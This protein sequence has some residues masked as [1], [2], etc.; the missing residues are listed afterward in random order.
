MPIQPLSLHSYQQIPDDEDVTPLGRPLT[1][2][3]RKTEKS[4]RFVVIVAV[5]ICVAA[6]VVFFGVHIAKTRSGNMVK[7][8]TSSKWDYSPTN[9]KFSPPLS[10]KMF[11]SIPC[12]NSIAEDGST[13]YSCLPIERLVIDRNKKYQKILGFGGAFT[14]SSAHN[15]YKMPVDVQKKFMDLYFGENGIGLNMGRIHIGSCDFSLSS[16]N[17][18]IVPNDYNLDYF[19]NDVTRDNIEIIPFILDAMMI[20]KRSIQLVASPWSPPPWM[21]VPF[22]NGNV[23]MTGSASPNGLKDDPQTKLAW[24]RYLSKFV[25]AYEMKGINIWAITPQNEPEFPAPWEACAYNVSFEK[26]FIRDYLGPVFRAEHPD[27]KILAFDHNKDHLQSWTQTLLVDGRDENVVGVPPP[28]EWIVNNTSP[29]S[30]YIDGMAFHWYGGYDRTTDGT[31]GYNTLNASYHLAPDKIFLN[32]EGCSCP[33]VELGNWLRA[34]RLGHD[35]IFDL[36]NYAQGWIDWNLLVDSRGKHALALFLYFLNFSSC[37]VLSQVVQIIYETSAT[38]LWSPLSNM[39]ISFCNQNTITSVIYPS[40]LLRAPLVSVRNW[41]GITNLK[42]SI[43]RFNRI[44]NC[45]CF[46]VKN[47]FDK[48]GPSIHYRIPCT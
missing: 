26:E 30:A 46:L 21:K 22:S 25:S 6:V 48:C 16:Y 11:E 31:Y 29:L 32:T 7:I 3:F 27:L 8:Y 13:D 34:E 10:M 33:G 17:F 1:K 15:Y 4:V 41:S 47:L 19:D 35:I 45:P 18:D 14:E 37:F 24:A 43:L 38:L 23:S 42:V 39:M 2:N 20:S 36:L 28:E 9:S 12:A 5:L 44:L 40:L